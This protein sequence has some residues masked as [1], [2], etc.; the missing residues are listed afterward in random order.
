M[1][2]LKNLET[3]KQTIVNCHC[4][5]HRHTLVFGIWKARPP[6]IG[7]GEINGPPKTSMAELLATK[8][9]PNSSGRVG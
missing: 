8:Q 4:T 3:G 1:I 6:P 2:I 7:A 9:D 5:C